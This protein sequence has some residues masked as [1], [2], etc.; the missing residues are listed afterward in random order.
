MYYKVGKIYSNDDFVPKQKQ[1]ENTRSKGLGDTVEK[2]LEKTGIASLFHKIVPKSKCGCS[3]RKSLLN[4][5]VPYR[6]G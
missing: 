1:P 5:L 6:G 2:V 4:K 3:K